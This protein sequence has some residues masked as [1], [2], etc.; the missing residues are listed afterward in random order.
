V[1][2]DLDIDVHFAKIDT[3]G[4]RVV[5]TFHVHLP[6]TIDHSDLTARLL[7]AAAIPK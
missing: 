6:D 2:H 7:A 4:G 1:L 3:Q 5:D